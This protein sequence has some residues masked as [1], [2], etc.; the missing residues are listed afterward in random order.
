MEMKILGGNKPPQRSYVTIRLN[1]WANHWAEL[2]NNITEYLSLFDVYVFWF[3][4]LHDF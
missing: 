4:F 2:I 3:S 1:C